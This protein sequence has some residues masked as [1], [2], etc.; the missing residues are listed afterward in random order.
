M[1]S[2]SWQKIYFEIAKTDISKIEV[3]G[4]FINSNCISKLTFVTIIKL[5]KF[6]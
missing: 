3:N 4:K 5:T 1:T 2:E 6:I